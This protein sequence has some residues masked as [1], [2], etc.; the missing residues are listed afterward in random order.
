MSR[1]V[2]FRRR[3]RWDWRNERRR[4]R[5]FCANFKLC[6]RSRCLWLDCGELDRCRACVL[7]APLYKTYN[8]SIVPS[9]PLVTSPSAPDRVGGARPVSGSAH[10][11]CV[12][13]SLWSS[14]SKYCIT[15]ERNKVVQGHK[16]L[17]FKEHK[18]YLLLL[19]LLHHHRSWRVKVR[20]LSTC[21]QCNYLWSTSD[22]HSMKCTA[23]F[24]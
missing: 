5:S 3:G 7:I 12:W 24:S 8:G 4:R 22:R 13:V 21:L 15:S 1:K 18:V 19:L 17:L 6:A 14:M 9:G 23:R 16:L 10:V 20:V 2:C 11:P